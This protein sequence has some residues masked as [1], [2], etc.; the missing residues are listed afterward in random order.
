MVIS[1]QL[2]GLEWSS[3]LSIEQG[4]ICCSVKLRMG[5]L[6]PVLS[7]FRIMGNTLVYPLEEEE[8][9]F[10]QSAVVPENMGT[11]ASEIFRK[12]IIAVICR[13]EMWFER[14]GYDK[15]YGGRISAGS[16]MD[17]G[18]HVTPQSIGNKEANPLEEEERFLKQSPIFPGKTGPQASINFPEKGK[19][20]LMGRKKCGSIG[21]VM[22]DRLVGELLLGGNT[23]VYPLEE[24]EKTFNQSAVIPE[25]MGTQTSEIFRKNIIAVICRNEMWF[26]RGGYDKSY[27]GRISAGSQMDK[28]GHVTPQS[29]GNKE[30][31]PLEEEDRVFKQSPIFPGKTGPQHQ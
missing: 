20:A 25:K 29:I 13:N 8:K 31:N 11:Q 19:L 21:G 24:K 30:A 14:G 17:K 16:Q 9:T 26:E 3:D 6:T 7:V 18:G 27:G 2:H 5:S 12:N 4:E 23:L 1:A 10:N 28:G 22:I 15:S